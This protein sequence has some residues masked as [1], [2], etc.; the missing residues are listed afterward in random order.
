M[1]KSKNTDADI[2]F[3]KDKP[4]MILAVVSCVL[5]ALNVILTFILLRS[6]D[7]K[8]PVQYIVNDGSVLQTSNW[9]SLYSLAVFSIASA[10]AAV[11]I[12][13]RL[14]KGNRLFSIGVLAVYCIIGVITLLSTFALLNLVSKV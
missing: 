4:V 7:F 5:A 2:M 9:Y 3:T 14:H 11:F 8:V 1:E 6:H 10:V 12:A 13:R